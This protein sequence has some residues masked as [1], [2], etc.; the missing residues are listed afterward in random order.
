[1]LERE[2]EGREEGGEGEGATEEG[3]ENSCQVLPGEEA[4]VRLLVTGNQG[5][6]RK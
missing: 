3:Q 2:V 6:R 1:M 4:E 5:G